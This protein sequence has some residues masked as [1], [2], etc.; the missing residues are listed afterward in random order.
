MYRRLKP[1]II[2]L[3]L[4]VLAIAMNP[5]GNSLE[6]YYPQQKAMDIAALTIGN[7]VT[8]G[9]DVV[10]ESKLRKVPVIYHPEYIM[11]DLKEQQFYD[12]FVALTT[13]A[14]ETPLNE[15]T[16]AH[17]SSHGT[18]QGF[19]GPGILLVK[20]DKLVVSPPDTFV[21]GF[22]KAYT[23]GV[24][25]KSGLEIWENEKTVKTVPYSDISNSTVPHNYVT[26][27]TL[28]KWCNKADNGAK[29]TLNYGLSNFNDNRNPVAPED[30][31][32][33]FGND[34]LEYMENYP[35]GS[36]VMVYAKFSTETV[37]GTGADVLGSYA[38]YSTTARAYNAMQF[39]KGW[40]NTI[41][42]PHTTSHG[43]ETVGFQGISDP[44]APE[45]SA[46]HGVCPAARS[47]RSAVMSD[48]FPLPVGMSSGEYAVLYGFEP[49]AGILLKNTNDYPVK[50]VM[51]TTGSGAG[52][53]IY[54]KA[55][56]LA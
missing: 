46:T 16:G 34:V 56:A 10:D 42:P 30:I 17:I 38:N 6:N 39:V 40:N 27:K 55:I 54:T 19:E 51:W 45:D 4:I 20:G 8:S 22:K 47:L 52:L 5:V 50:I 1:I 3:I 53:H 24:K 29:I 15:L 44:H 18:A 14:I 36:P 7:T 37:V 33:F 48:G 26:V 43:K 2:L 28:K 9:M 25:T 41:I 13:G 12:L 23:Y 49:S 11:N 32:T 35:S 21:W 31:E